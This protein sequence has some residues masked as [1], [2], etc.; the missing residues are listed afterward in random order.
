MKQ[1]ETIPDT[2][3]CGGKRSFVAI[4]WRGPKKGGGKGDSNLIKSCEEINKPY[5]TSQNQGVLLKTKVSFN[6]CALEW[7]K[8]LPFGDGKEEDDCIQLGSVPSPAAAAALPWLFNGNSDA[9]AV[10]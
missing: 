10:S 5:P 2:G 4:Q 1:T 6:L 9:W 3:G 7:K 8:P